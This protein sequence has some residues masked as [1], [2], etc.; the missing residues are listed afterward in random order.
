[1]LIDLHAH[2]PHPGFLDQHPHWGPTYVPSADGDVNLR[3]G[4]WVL[5]LGIPERR[6]A[7]AAGNI[8]SREETMRQRADPH[9]RLAQMDAAKQDIQV[10]SL[11]SHYAMYWADKEFGKAYAENTNRVMEEYCSADPDRLKFFAH[12]AL[13]DPKVAAA[14]LEHAVTKRGAVGLGMGGANFGGLE[15]HDEEFY[16]VWE[17]VSKL[18]IPVFVHGFNQSVTWGEDADKEPFDV[19]AIVGM[20]YDETRLFWYMINGGVLDR[21]PDL[22]IYITHGGGYVP[23][24]LGRLDMTNQNL[25]T[26][27]NKEPLRHYMKNFYFDPL[28]HELPMRQAV[29][30]VIDADNLLYGSNFGGS[31]AIREDLSAPLKMSD[32]NREKLRWKN[33]ARLLKLDISADTPSLVAA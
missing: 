33:A 26:A 19:T 17:M 9:F 4:K 11:P 6:Q 29:I 31:D 8:I 20:P 32:E 1:M 13:Q 3:I 16:P 2:L 24:Q 7:V 28:I 22:K 30:D 14:E 10:L 25:R 12:T 27:K 18:D 23:Y 15:V 5:H 21:F